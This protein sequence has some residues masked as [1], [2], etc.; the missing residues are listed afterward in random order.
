MSAL[1]HSDSPNDSLNEVL[2][3]INEL[4]KKLVG[5]NYIYRG[6]RKCY[7]N[8]KISSSLYRQYQGLKGLDIEV[9]QKRM[10]KDAEKYTTLTDEHEILS[11]IQHFGGDTNLIDFTTDYLI[12]LFFA[13]DGAM[14]EDGRLIL[15]QNLEDASKCIW[16]PRTP[17]NRIIAQKSVFV[18]PKTGYLEQESFRAIKVPSSL[19]DHILKYLRESHG[20]SRETIYNDL[21]GFIKNREIHKRAH[22]EFYWALTYQYRSNNE[23]AIEHYDEV[24]KLKPDDPEAYI[25]RGAVY[26]KKDDFEKA[27]QDCT[28]AIELKPDYFEPYYNRGC[29]YCK[30]GDFEQAIQD[31]T[32]AIELKPNG[33]GAYI[34]R[35]IAYRKKGDF[36]QA[37]QDYTKAIELKPDD[38]GAYNSRGVAYYE[39]GDFEQAIQDYTK[40]I[41]LKPD[42]FGA[43]NN[44][45]FIYIE[46]G[47]LDRALEDLERAEALAEEQGLSDLLRRIRKPLE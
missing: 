12:A 40:A 21:H 25:N 44:R 38:P 4:A 22:E 3:I 29:A 26:L 31:C 8:G 46:K 18:Q 30:K 1:N 10:V 14:E 13:C 35:G 16:Y 15:L 2:E 5:G 45:G 23:K 7:G 6:E 17:K 11:Q 39:K 37:I 41:E 32:K 34:N 20:I 9:V 27:I 24:I 47:D 33:P 42:Y 43:Y 19:K 28:K 36:E